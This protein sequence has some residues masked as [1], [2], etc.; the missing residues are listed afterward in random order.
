MKPITDITVITVTY[1]SAH[2]IADLQKGLQDCAHVM[3]VDNASGDTTVQTI[4]RLMP[5]A[6]IFRNEKNLGFGAANNR[7]LQQVQTPY[8][9][10]LNPDCEINA[11]V[12]SQLHQA[13]QQ[14]PDAAMI[15]PQLMT[16]AG[17][18]VVDYRWLRSE[19]A[20]AG[21][22]ADAPTC[23]GFVS[24]AIILLNMAVM[25]QVGFFDEDFF[26]YY[27]DDDLCER[28]HQASKAVIVMPDIHTVHHSRGS[29]KG[30]SPWRSEYLRGYHHAQS[31]II[32]AAKH[33]GLSKAR[34]LR[35][36]TLV[37]ALVTLPFRCLAPVPKHLARLW[38]RIRGLM[39]QRWPTSKA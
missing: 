27:E 11:E 25:R 31:K 24:G 3:F 2:C 26:L 37:L 18:P 17:K 23:V 10:L 13:A 19:W 14:F 8:A 29:V 21:V 39:A 16:T 20:S 28:V 38:G 7:A 36:K 15:A 22:G 4:E 33:Q 34:S 9:L 1:N 32:F 35:R 6:Q 5:Q 30:K 12:M